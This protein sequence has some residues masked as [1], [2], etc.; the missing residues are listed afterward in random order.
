LSHKDIG[1]WPFINNPWPWALPPL[2]PDGAFT[3][4]FMGRAALEAA[5]GGAAHTLP[6]VGRDPRK[7]DE[8]EAKALLDGLEI[9]TVLTAVADM[10]IGR[11]DGKVVGLA[12]PGLPEGWSPK[13]LVCGFVKVDRALAA[14]TELILKDARRQLKVEIVDDI[15]PGRSARWPLN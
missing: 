14:G 2:G 9:G 4:D 10:G 5:R 11:L 15:R 7:V 8:R 13:G 12:S 6:F 3:K 1:E